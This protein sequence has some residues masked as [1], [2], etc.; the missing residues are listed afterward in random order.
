MS[1]PVDVRRLLRLEEGLVHSDVYTSPEIFELEMD[2][3]FHEGW[4]YIGHDSEIP[5]PGDY[6]LR[7]IGRQS[8]IMN[9]DSD[10]KLHLFMNRCRHRANS[11]CQYDRGNAAEF[12][13][14]YH[15]W[16]Y[17]NSGELI[18]LP[19]K[20][21][22]YS[23]DFDMKALPLVAVRME[24]Y[25]GF[26]WGN[27]GSGRENLREHLGPAG[28]K[29]I[30][31]FCDASPEGEVILRQGCNKTR[32]FANWKFQGGD[33]YHTPV[34]H[35][36][37]FA[38]MRARRNGERRNSLVRGRMEDGWISRDLGNGHYCLDS[39]RVLGH[40]V[41]LPDAP[42]ART[43]R[44]TM[45]KSYGEE[46]ADY[47]IKTGGNPHA[48]LMPNLQLL[49]PDV[50]VIRPH[51]VDEFDVFFYCAFLK[52]VPDELNEMRL[53]D[54]E[55][56]M[57]PA[58]SINPDDVDMFERNQFGMQQVVDPWKFM[59]RGIDREAIDDDADTPEPYRMPGTHIGHYSDEVTQRAQLRWWADRISSH[60]SA[61]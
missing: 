52:G 27:L 44:A 16:T 12:Q 48:I 4:V 36:A 6:V 22:A 56:R 7:P 29:S 24:T 9:R 39:R 21:G 28:L 57:G 46:R 8:V 45:V 41:R 37:N 26:I 43:Y 34:T 10:G 31:L 1:Q 54:T 51:A 13:C 55:D 11:V 5:S 60:D 47:I 35:Q 61:K 18:A 38:V 2:K 25:R 59:A 17:R 14:S 15:G 32:I 40:G 49:S 50:R 33:G 58:G 3:L 19:Y 20:D 23:K 30:D 53:R 42:W